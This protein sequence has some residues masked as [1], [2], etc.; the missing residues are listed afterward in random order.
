MSKTKRIEELKEELINSFDEEQ[1]QLHQQLV[2]LQS[3]L[4]YAENELH[5]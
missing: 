5:N 4:E 1:L 3:E 2:F